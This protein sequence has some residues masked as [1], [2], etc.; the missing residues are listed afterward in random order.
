MAELI[1]TE[2]VETADSLVRELQRA[3]PDPSDPDFVESRD[4]DALRMNVALRSTLRVAIESITERP[5][6]HPLTNPLGAGLAVGEATA[7][8]RV[9]S[10]IARALHRDGDERA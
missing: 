9:I 7:A 3:C 2:H 10:T 1:V 4:G 6:P 5:V 8:R